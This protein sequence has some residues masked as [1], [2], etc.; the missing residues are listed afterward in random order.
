MR[1]RAFTAIAVALGISG[2]AATGVPQNVEPVAEGRSYQAQYRSAEDNLREARNARSAALNAERCIAP[3]APPVPS[4]APALL[5]PEALSPGDL[6]AVVVGT[7]EVFTGSFEVSADGALRLPHLSAIPVDGRDAPSLESAI[8]DRLVRE[9]LYR[10]A[11]RVSVRLTDPAGAR[12]SVVGAV[13]Q[14]GP[15]GVGGTSGED[16]DPT[17]QL[18]MGADGSARSLSAALRAAG[19]VRPDADLSTV[20]LTRAGKSR[21]LDMRGVMEGR[22]FEDA[23]L[24]TGDRIEVPSRG[25]FQEALM[26]SNAVSPPGVSVY[27]SNLT[28]PADANALSAIGRETRQMP[29]GTRFLQ[30]AV[31]MNCVGGAALTNADRYAVLFSRNPITGQSIVIERRL[32]DLLRR[33]D[34]DEL[35]PYLMPGDAIACYDSAVT[36]ITEVAKSVAVVLGTG[37][38][39]AL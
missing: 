29:Y 14:P 6:L 15:H 8:A 11:P 27:M 22:A 1:H 2:C 19:G 3:S 9:G 24:V 30:A 28:K 39:L 13:F 32:E 34:R 10:R 33:A 21:V 5:L 23:T 20:R 31:N 18:A 16:R 36:N 38:L 25:C 4:A 12:V 35:D 17:R 37:L 7:D 26:V